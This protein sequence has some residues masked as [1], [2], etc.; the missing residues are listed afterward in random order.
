MSEAEGLAE[1]VRRTRPRVCFVGHHH[2]RV[3]AEI[4]GI[5]CI[6]LNKVGR[7]GN[8][9]AVEI[10][11][12]QPGFHILGEWPLPRTAEARGAP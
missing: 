7:S 8:L 11:P 1:A 2:R 3:D 9:I 12:G 4:D 6:S 5:R 10:D